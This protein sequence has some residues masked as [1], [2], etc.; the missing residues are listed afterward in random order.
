MKHED[1]SGSLNY[2]L[3]YSELK[4]IKAGVQQGSLLGPLLYLLYSYVAPVLHSTT[5][6]IILTVGKLQVTK[7][8]K[9]KLQETLNEMNAWRIKFKDAKL[10]YINFTNRRINKS[11]TTPNNNVVPQLYEGSYII[12]NII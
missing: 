8:T 11:S 5:N 12:N 2:E 7:V 9:E 4:E 1:M 3:N 6:A 10:T